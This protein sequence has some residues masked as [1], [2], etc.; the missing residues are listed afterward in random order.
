MGSLLDALAGGAM[1]AVGSV[2]GGLINA[3]E[4]ERTNAMTIDLANTQYQRRA[5]DLAAAGINPLMAGNLGGANVPTLQA[6][7][8][9]GGIAAAAQAIGRI[10]ENQRIL[11]QQSQSIAQTMANTAQINAQKD[12]TEADADLARTQSALGQ[13]E[14][15]FVAPKAQ[16]TINKDSASAAELQAQADTLNAVR[17]PTVKQILQQTAQS[18]QATQTDATRQQEMQQSLKLAKATFGAKV[19][20]AIAFTRQAVTTADNLNNTQLSEQQKNY[21]TAELMKQSAWQTQINAYL[22]KKYGDVKNITDIAG[23]VLGSI[24]KGR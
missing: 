17:D 19:D 7:Q 18:A 15:P 16:M 5:K 14:L 9:G 6:P 11:E 20:E 23:N 4:Q 13:A 1:D 24:P 2:A 8:P 12:K 3:G 22:A 10:P 21:Q